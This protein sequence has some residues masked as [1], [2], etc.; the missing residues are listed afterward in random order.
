[1]LYTRDVSTSQV[2]SVWLVVQHTHTHNIRCT[3]LAIRVVSLLCSLPLA[4]ATGN[5]WIYP[6]RRLPFSCYIPYYNRI[7]RYCVLSV[8][9][10]NCIMRYH[11]S[12]YVILDASLNYEGRLQQP[13]HNLYLSLLLDAV[14]NT[15]SPFLCQQVWN[16]LFTTFWLVSLVLQLR[17]TGSRSL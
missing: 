10:I 9:L 2:S 17:Y 3:S 1:M 15:V 14:V 13:L 16:F 6:R 12:F 8:Y 7:L 4:L 11:M 5:L